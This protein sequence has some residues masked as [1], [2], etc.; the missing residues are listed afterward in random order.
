MGLL[1]GGALLG[2]TFGI[3]CS[4]GAPAPETD[5]TEAAATPAPDDALTAQ[6]AQMAAAPME[7]M[8]L[9]SGLVMLSGPGG[10]V[11]VLHGPDGKIVAD[12]F[13]LPAWSDLKSTLDGLGTAPV[14][15]VINTHWHFDHTDNNASFREAGAELVAHENTTQRLSQSHELLG[16]RIEPAPEAA[17]PTETFATTHTIEANGETIN[18]AYIPPAHT[19]TD[20]SIHYANAN[21]IHAGDVFFNGIY[22]FI[23]AGTGGTINGM[24]GGAERLLKMGD[25]ASRYVPGHGP[26]AD[27]AALTRYRDMLATSRDRVQK[28]KSAGGSL[29]EVQAA[30]PTADLDGTWGMGFMM[31]NDF[32]ALVYSTL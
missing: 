4:T 23:D 19:D 32:V 24:V 22:P 8:E 21:V 15:A 14:S 17:R 25:A 12:T 28:L 30:Q 27:R 6:R 5:T 2:G 31:P 7:M 9:A 16:M 26:L 3:G 20:I 11:V 10:N 18:L 13:V 1:G 29:E